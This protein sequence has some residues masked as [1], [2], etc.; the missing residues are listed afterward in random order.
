MKTIRQCTDKQEW[1]DYVLEN[2][3][4]PLQLWGWGDLKSANGWSADRL[5]LT[6]D[7]G[8]IIGAAQVLYRKL[9]WPFK[10]IAYI[11]RG[12]VVDEFNRV[13]L[14]IKL[15]EYVKSSHH[16]IA[17]S[18]EPD[19]EEF[20]I[21][22]AWIKSKN[23]ILPAETLILDLN[24]SEDQLQS[25]MVK[26]TRQYIR[27]SS[28]EATIIKK[29]HSREEL[30]KCLDLYHDTSKRAKFSLHNDQYYYD[31]FEKMG[32]F[33]PLFATYTDDQPV[34]FLW[35][36]IS[37]STAFELYGG[38]NEIGQQLR[39]NYALKWHAIHKCKEWGL[40]RYDFGGLIEGGVSTFKKGWSET[41]TELA[42]TFDC[43]MS[44]FYGLWGFALPI[45]KIIARKLRSLLGH[46]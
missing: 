19:T 14:L 5:L 12:P 41:E 33:A 35:L 8:K 38:M 16:P 34:A 1:D 39:A 23:H 13:I 20:T 24:K 6:E 25:E 44:V 27:K 32:D 29:I 10:S 37:S 28:N 7:D 36:A 4:H 31:M 45:G 2:G 22:K 26:K 11:P 3:G 43:P 21:P 46:H 40:T 17:L 30:K 42:G 9:I 15:T 18:I